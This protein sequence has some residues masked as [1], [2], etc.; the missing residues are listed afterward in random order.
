[1][2]SVA[3]VF[4]I[5]FFSTCAFA[6]GLQ[7]L[8]EL[9]KGQEEIQKALKEEDRVFESVKRAV[10]QGDIRI[11]QSKESIVKSYGEPVVAIDEKETLRQRCV[12]KPSSSTYFEGKKIYLYFNN[13][14]MLENIKEVK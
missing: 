13:S 3:F 12:Y 11:G 2:R 6:E 7:T 4:F 10:E 14:G 5:L 8:I 9:G 1:M